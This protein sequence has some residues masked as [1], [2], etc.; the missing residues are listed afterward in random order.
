MIII[1]QAL[2]KAKAVLTHAEYA[3]LKQAVQKPAKPQIN[4]K[5]AEAVYIST[6]PLEPNIVSVFKA[7]YSPDPSAL[8]VSLDD[9]K[10]DGLDVILAQVDAKNV[11]ALGS[12]AK[13]T[14]DSAGREAIYLPHP[15]AF[16]ADPKKTRKKLDQILAENSQNEQDSAITVAINKADESKHIVYSIALDPYQHDAHGDHISTAE[17]EKVAHNWLQKSRKI[18]LNHE[19][20]EGVGYVVESYVERYPT[21]EEYKKA[22]ANKPHR[23]FKLPFGEDVVHSGAWVLGIKLNDQAWELHKE[24]KLNA[25]SIGGFGVRT[26]VDASKVPEVT[27]VELTEQSPG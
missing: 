17:I 5:K 9:A 22:L 3:M 10:A 11:Y 7:E 1:D 12:A 13:S 16:R 26:P 27:F 24:G 18:G 23:A 8:V 14:L 25:F 20:F 2:A 21:P 15:H 4:V 19:H 6:T